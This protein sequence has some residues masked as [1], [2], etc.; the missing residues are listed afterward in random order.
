ML[1]KQL[2]GFLE[3]GLASH[4]GTRNSTLEPNAA[5]VIAVR[6]DEDRRHV[7]AYVPSVAARAV[8][9]DLESNGQ[10][11]LV[12]TRPPDDKG[13]QVK[14]VFTD[15]REAHADER[16]AVLAQWERFR[17]SLEAIGLPR[18]ASDAWVTWPAVAI[19]FRVNAVFDQTPGPGAGAPIA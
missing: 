16:A 19:R 11:T 7:V 9:P 8:L 12:C 14:G 3:E 2:A 6:V 1:D 5:R 18:V 15:A 17:D 10:V 4:L 13:C